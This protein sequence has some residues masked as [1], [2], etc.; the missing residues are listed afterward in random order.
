MVTFKNYNDI[1]LDMLDDLRLTQPSLDVKPNSVARDLFV[2]CQAERI[3]EIYNLLR[4]ISSMQSIANVTGQDLTN[5][6]ANYG[7]AR[8]VGT[9]AI[10]TVIFT[11]RSVD[12]DISIPASSVVRTRNGIPFLT[13]SAVTVYRTQSNS[14]KATATRLRQDLDTA[15]ITDEYAIEVSVEAQ[16][17]GSI[18]NISKFAITSC[19]I[20]GVNSV[21]NISSFTGGTNLEDD[22]SFRARILA[23]FTGTNVGTALGYKSAVLNLA[24]ALDA[25]VVE[26]GDSLMT[27]DGTQ[28]ST[29]SGTTVVTE[30]GT[31]GKVDIYVMGENSQSSIDSFIYKD[32]SGRD[33]PTDSLNDYVL[34]QSSLTPDVT[35]T[36]NSRR[37]AALSG[38]YDLPTQPIINITSVSGSSSGPNFVEQYL[39]SVGNL[40]GNYKLTKDTGIAG[41]SVFGLDKLSWTSNQIELENE[42]N[43]KGVFNGID[44]LFY[45]NVLTIPAIRQEIQ[46]VN[47]NSTVSSS[48]NYVTTKH[49]P[50]KTVTRVFNLTT[51]E[52]YVV[53]DQNPDGG[54]SNTTGKIRI[55]GRTLPTASD[56][57][58]VDYV[59]I[60]ELDPH[61]D[62]DNFNPRDENDS[63]QDSIEWGFSN[64]IRDELDTAILDSYGNLNITT[65][66]LISRVLSVNV[67]Y[68]ETLS[69]GGTSSKKTITT[70]RSVN[71]IHSI[72]DASIAGN[73]EVYNTKEGDGAYS[74]RLIT[75]PS[76][77]LASIGDIVTVIYNLEDKFVSDAYGNGLVLNNKI[78]I[79]PSTAITSGTQVFVNYVANFL[80][81][82][83]STNII[84]FPVS[85]DGLNSFIGIDG[86]QPLQNLYS[87]T[88]I[89]ANQRRS[90][91]RLKITASSIPAQGTI[92]IIGTTFN[93]VTGIFPSTANNTINLASAIR[94]AE[95]LS[96]T[97]TIPTTITVAKVKSVEEVELTA[98]H[99]FKSVIFEY[100]ITNYSIKNN[101]WDKAY[102]IQLSSLSN[103]VVK[104]ADTITNL[105]NPIT[106]GKN[107]RVIFYYVKEN[108]YEDMFFSKN[109]TFITD[110]RF[111]YISSVN[112]LSGM[113]DSGGSISGSIV[114]DTFNQPLTN[115][116]YL[117]DYNY[118]APQDNERI[119]INYQYNKL[120][121]DAT[122]SI[123]EKRPITSD[124]LVKAATKVEIDVEAS[125]VVTSAYADR[126]TSVQQDV[127]DNIT[128]TL[129]AST[130]GTT[131]DSS[132]IIDNAYNVAGL[133]RI[134]IL[135]FNKSGSSGLKLSI[136]AEKNEYLAPGTVTVTVENR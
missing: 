48:R 82:L 79:L 105:E 120:I 32:E 23:I 1:V 68:S 55:T 6:G 65:T 60:C 129:S 59:W 39:D 128:A 10:G 33:D 2:D 101:S 99:E 98:A 113:Q 118:T 72:R 71:N 22:A 110:K 97:A 111:A 61:I 28:V 24:E 85:G 43:T 89:V 114:I 115:Y 44:S 12:S 83:P 58:Q 38:D 46:V 5:Y 135:Q 73:P 37:V 49:A 14:L 134:R 54:D 127:A 62:Y 20:S 75:L 25:I 19:N 78:T 77:S 117:V 40:K 70:T 90:P 13:I 88:A 116:S 106:T 9:K 36:L 4:Q 15:G 96:N 103:T 26:P 133:D 35:L 63:A 102:A 122:E 131:I 53:A 107:L 7:V 94:E 126:E 17:T 136:S 21:T 112:R 42:S 16:S 109:G 81:I 125:I 52:R 119:T 51:G 27:R 95:G 91:S 92:R 87:G 34:G 47:E 69:V 57:L 41:G 18:G 74:Y 31:G 30:P 3:S 8:K 66:Y 100:D 11:F 121:A 86:Y 130:L 93:L 45:S 56:I 124:V 123:E 132:D 29:S 108:S 50:I 104:L 84:N 76:D 67:F 64:Y 80:N